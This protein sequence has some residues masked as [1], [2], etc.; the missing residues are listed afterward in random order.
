MHRAVG[1]A[2]VRAGPPPPDPKSASTRPFSLLQRT[3]ERLHSCS[4]PRHLWE[5]IHDEHAGLDISGP[6]ERL[7]SRKLVLPDVSPA[8]GRPRR[9][10]VPARNSLFDKELTVADFEL[11]LRAEGNNAAKKLTE[12]SYEALA[13]AARQAPTCVH[14]GPRRYHPSTKSS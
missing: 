3:A 8:H 4:L 13:K 7:R 5:C 1:A 9:C 11:A 10:F 2:G 14:K 12:E 6:W